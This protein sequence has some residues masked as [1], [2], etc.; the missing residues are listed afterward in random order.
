MNYRVR[1][2]VSHP[3]IWFNNCNVVIHQNSMNS[4]S[5]TESRQIA[6]EPKNVRHAMCYCNSINMRVATASEAKKN[7]IKMMCQHRDKSR[8]KRQS[9]VNQISVLPSRKRISMAMAREK[10]KEKDK[11]KEKNSSAWNWNQA[12][13]LE[14]KKY[15]AN[16]LEL[17]FDVLWI[18]FVV[19]VV[20][21]F[22]QR[23]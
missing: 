11:R 16:Q 18:M 20:V 4:W 5:R 14:W 23:K 13:S 22:G 7:C 9:S 15:Y 12:N 21:V 1:N 2:D 8:E 3:E 17:A 6:Q 10:E 19:A